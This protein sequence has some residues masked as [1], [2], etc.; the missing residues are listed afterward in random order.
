MQNKNN[1]W[2]NL[3]P[4]QVDEIE[5]KLAKNKARFEFEAQYAQQQAMPQQKPNI[6][7]SMFGQQPVTPKPNTV[8]IMGSIPKKAAAVEVLRHLNISLKV[9]I[10]SMVG[11]FVVLLAGVFGNM[12]VYVAAGAFVVGMG[13]YVASLKKEIVRLKSEYSI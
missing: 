8:N 3:T 7:N 2:D 13:V 6:L 5:Q 12:P 9:S 11:I 4:E 1:D 10:G